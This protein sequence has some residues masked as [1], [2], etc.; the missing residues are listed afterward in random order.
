MCLNSGQTTTL[1]NEQQ[2]Q[3]KKEKINKEG[4]MEKISICDYYA[5]YHVFFLHFSF[6][7]LQKYLDPECIVICRN[8]SKDFP[9]FPSHLRRF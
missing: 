3:K 1:K 9:F 2:Q 8:D 4:A 5:T 6:V 7:T